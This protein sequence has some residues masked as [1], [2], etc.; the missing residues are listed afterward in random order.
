MADQ[1][2]T[3][4]KGWKMTTLGEVADIIMGQSPSG[5][6]YNQ[7]NDGLPFYQGITEFGDKYVNIKTFTN[8]P[9]KIIEANSILFSVRAPVGKVNFTK[10]KACIGRGNAG[11]KM[12]NGQQNFLY[13][14]LKKSEKAF[15]SN[16]TG[17]VFD[18]I[19]GWQLREF[20]V[21][22]PEREEEQCAIAAVLSSLDDKIELLREQ[23][24]TLEAT[25]Q[26]IFKEWFVNFNFPGATGKMIDSELGEIP[27]GW[28]VVSFDEIMKFTPGTYIPKEKYEIN[29]ENFIYG[30][31]SVM[32]N[33]NQKTHT[34]P[35]IIL[36]KIGTYCGAIRFSQD[37]CWINN[38]AGGI[39][40]L[41]ISTALIFEILKHF[42]FSI[43]QEGSGQP[44]INMSGLKMQK[45]AIPKDLNSEIL[46]K[47]SQCMD[48]IYLKIA[49]NQKH[50]QT[51]SKL[52]DT[53]LPK[54]I[55]GE[56]RV[57]GFK[58]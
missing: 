49:G 44:Y 15:L 14:L 3:I 5:E 23:N 25:A 53:L 56:I 40:G 29:G 13:F 8:A 42:D 37:D 47:I 58:D 6:S 28:R 54:L 41:N 50:I 30:S 19:S 12:K 1:T 22:I 11:L 35:I 7:K 9:T 32:G 43:V 16:T 17:T 18:S 27:E 48:T 10:H 24:K 21:L 20:E 52:R 2:T 46:K 31:N 36:A 26:A 55:K 45:V 38:N 34:G 51:L 4:P 33:I 57:K 39:Q